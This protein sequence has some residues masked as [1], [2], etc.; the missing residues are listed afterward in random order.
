MRKGFGAPAGHVMPAS[1]EAQRTAEIFALVI[2]LFNA[3]IS[4]LP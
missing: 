3:G 4:S 2:S 1:S